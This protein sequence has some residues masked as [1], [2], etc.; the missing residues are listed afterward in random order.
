MQQNRF[1]K[2]GSFKIFPVYSESGFKF[3]DISKVETVLDNFRETDYDK[4][5]RRQKILIISKNA[6]K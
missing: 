6:E 2:S 5:T 3:S 1:T 4:F